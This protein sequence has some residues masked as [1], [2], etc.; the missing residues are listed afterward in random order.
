MIR[1]YDKWS[2]IYQLMEL[3]YS[4]NYGQAFFIEL[5]NS[6]LQNSKFVKRMQS[7]FQIHHPSLCDIAAPTPYGDES[8]AKINARLSS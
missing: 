6:V 3:N 2:I 5:G 1:S 8:Q 7:V 4:E